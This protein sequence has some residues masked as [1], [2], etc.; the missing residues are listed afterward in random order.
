VPDRH[1]EDDT[2]RATATLP[3]L[4]VEIVHRQSPGGDAEQISINLQ[5]VPSFDA[6]GRFLETANP[7]LFWAHVAQMAWA[8][9]IEAARSI[10]LPLSVAPPTR[11]GGEEHR[12][13]RSTVAGA[14]PPV[15]DP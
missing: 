7:F 6:F 5:A 2:T 3:G 14:L 1:D 13:S 9:W 4:K 11:S 15:S 10:A 8:P 12:T